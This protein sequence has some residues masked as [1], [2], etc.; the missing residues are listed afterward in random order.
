[1]TEYANWQSGQVEN[2]VNLWVQ[3]R[4]RSIWSRG[5]TEGRQPDM[6]KAMVQLHPGG[7]QLPGGPLQRTK[8][9]SWS[10]GKTPARQAGNPGSNP[11]GSTNYGR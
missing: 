4:P 2:L 11:G 10:N 7:V 3:L 1:M 9:G 8:T 6:L 5:P